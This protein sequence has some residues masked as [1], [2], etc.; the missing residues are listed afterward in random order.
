VTDFGHIT[1]RGGMVLRADPA[2]PAGVTV[3]HDQA[4]MSRFDEWSPE[5]N[6]DLLHSSIN[7][8]IQSLEI[9]AQGIAEFP[10][11]P[12]DV[13][14]NLARQCWDETRHA[15]LFMRRL[16]AHDGHFGEFPII[17]Q[18]WGV[19]CSLD[20]LPARIA[21][22]NRI[23]EGGS[24]DILQDSIGYWQELGDL[25]TA[26]VLDAVL[27]DEVDHVGFA[28]R[29]LARLRTEDPRGLLK[30]V[31]ALSHLARWTDALTPPEQHVMREFDVNAE[32]RRHAGFSV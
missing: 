3:V 9:A 2:R 4:D 15:R 14:L 21:V 7:E 18:E 26:E 32:D 12:W 23:F 27:A 1:V 17:N 24:L 31:A 5:H 19:V 16:D 10:S 11:A 28:N 29:W 25:E 22:Q 20:S 30:A 13:R 6:R 8:E